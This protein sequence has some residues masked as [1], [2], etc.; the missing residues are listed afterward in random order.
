MSAL[1]CM[2]VVIKDDTQLWLMDS[3][4]KK[5]TNTCVENVVSRFQNFL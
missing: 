3:F 5:S 4:K 2:T 1:M